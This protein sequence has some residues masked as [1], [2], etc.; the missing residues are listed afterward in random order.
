[1]NRWATT[2]P[3]LTLPPA[4]SR[5]RR[6]QRQ[7]EPFRTS[8]RNSTEYIVAHGNCLLPLWSRWLPVGLCTH[9][10]PTGTQV[11][12]LCMNRYQQKG[13]VAIKLQKQSESWIGW[14]EER[15]IVPVYS[16]SRTDSKARTQVSVVQ[17][18]GGQRSSSMETSP[19]INLFKYI[20]KE[21]RPYSYSSL[22]NI[23]KLL[24]ILQHISR[25][26]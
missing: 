13:R 23:N 20:C 17:D 7:V 2:H 22:A 19:Q 4:C 9:T 6:E 24:I 8:T 25:L 26:A 15:S 16:K 5:N 18:S 14:L 21:F 12:I 10:D 1:M 3:Q 11:L